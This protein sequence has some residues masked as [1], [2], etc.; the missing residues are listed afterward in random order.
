MRVSIKQPPIQWKVSDVSFHCS[1]IRT[2]PTVLSGF[3]PKR[4][5]NISLSSRKMLTFQERGGP[6]VDGSE[7]R[8]SPVEGKVVEIQ[9]FTRFHTSHGG[10]LGFLNHQQYLKEFYQQ[11]SVPPR[12]ISA[13]TFNSA[14]ILL[15]FCQKLLANHW[16]SPFLTQEIDPR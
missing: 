2:T 8:V 10:C 5:L 3:S 15:R 1:C 11:K 13:N 9:L 6:T 16:S 4:C 12:K 14:L 7:I